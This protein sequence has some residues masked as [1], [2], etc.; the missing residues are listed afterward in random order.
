[1]KNILFKTLIVNFDGKSYVIIGVITHLIGSL[2]A[3]KSHRK[4]S[5]NIFSPHLLIPRKVTVCKQN[6]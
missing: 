2:S 5:H 6:V 1:M 4:K 3:L